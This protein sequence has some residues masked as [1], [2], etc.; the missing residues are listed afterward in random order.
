MIQFPAFAE[1]LEQFFF[2]SCFYTNVE[3]SLKHLRS[4]ISHDSTFYLYS[5]H[6]GRK[7]IA[8]LRYVFFNEVPFGFILARRCV[9]IYLYIHT[10]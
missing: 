1:S 10:L 9:H 6:L 8:Q 7:W 4:D 5:L 2:G 3:C